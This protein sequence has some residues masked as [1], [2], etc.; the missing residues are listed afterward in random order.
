MEGFRERRSEDKS[1]IGEGVIEMTIN[2]AA[3]REAFERVDASIK[4]ASG[5]QARQWIAA[6]REELARFDLWHRKK[7]GSQPIR[8]QDRSV[9]LEGW[10]AR[11]QQPAPQPVEG[12][13]TTN[14]YGIWGMP[15][16]QPGDVVEM[17][18]ENIKNYWQNSGENFEYIDCAKAA[19]SAMPQ[20]ADAAEAMVLQ[21]VGFTCE[22]T[23]ER[24][25]FTSMTDFI[26]AFL[27]MK[28][29]RDEAKQ[30]ALS[31]NEAV[32]IMETA[33]DAEWGKSET[34]ELM[35]RAAYRA[36]VAAGVVNHK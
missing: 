11:A 21:K 5:E 18:A 6:N 25:T 12:P 2:E 1:E 10:Q 36:L 7:Y 28:K 24:H 4:N 8:P 32:E 16:Q 19:L 9:R 20:Q 22:R 27:L 34:L 35:A 26:M 3:E 30:P 31:E 29:E 14:N 33:M 23:G 15:A 13:D 17:V